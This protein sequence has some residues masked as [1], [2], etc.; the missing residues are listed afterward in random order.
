MTLEKVNRDLIKEDAEQ[1]ELVPFH[2]K[3]QL[4]EQYSVM[5]QEMNQSML[6][7]EKRLSDEAIQSNEKIKASIL[8]TPRMYRSLTSENDRLCKLHMNTIFIR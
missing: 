8:I 5:V 3:Q 4:Q 1:T 6:S 7:M 2:I